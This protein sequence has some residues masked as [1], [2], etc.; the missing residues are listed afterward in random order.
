MAAIAVL[1]VV[2]AATAVVLVSDDV[3][4]DTTKTEKIGEY[5]VVFE[6]SMDATIVGDKITFSGYATAATVSGDA[7]SYSGLFNQGDRS[8]KDVLD[9]NSAPLF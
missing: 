3:S 4:A 8:N 1:A 7:S 2:F 6:N 5:E 9:V